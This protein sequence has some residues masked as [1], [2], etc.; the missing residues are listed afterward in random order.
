[1]Y[2]H[3][4]IKSLN[5]S[6]N[7]ATD[8]EDKLTYGQVNKLFYEKGTKK[9]NIPVN[10]EHAGLHNF[11]GSIWFARTFKSNHST[12]KLNILEFKGIDYFA[13]VWL[14]D[15]FLG[16]HEGYF[17]SF[18]FDIS[19]MLRESGK[20]FLIVKVNSPL[21]EPKKV[22]PYRKRLI[23]GIFNHH[24]CRPGAWSYKY[25][26]DQNTGGIWNEVVL[27]SVDEVFIENVRVKPRIYFNQNKAL[28]NLSVSFYKRTKAVIKD[29]M[30]IRVTSPSGKII[31]LKKDIHLR[32]I[33]HDIN[34]M[35]VIKN[36]ELWWSWDLG[37]PNLYE[38]NISGKF[39]IIKNIKFG[40]REVRINEKK[41]FYLNGKRLFLRGTNVIPALF[42]S[43][44]NEKKIEEQLGLIKDANINIIRMHAHVNR[45]E[46][47]EECDKQGILIWQDFAL[48]WTYDESQ[49]FIIN[50]VA[51]IMDMV[52]LLFNHASIA[53]WCCHNEP[54]KQ[55]ESLDPFL[56]DA[57]RS[58]D[59]SRI[60][61]VAS[62]YEE[63][64][65]DG[66]YWGNK[67]HFAARPMGPLVTEFGAQALPE[68]KS[69]KKI[70]PGTDLSDPSKESWAYHDFQYE[71]TFNIAD[72]NRGKN[73]NE[74]IK[75]S[76]DYQS[77]LL[78]TAIDFYRRGKNK[79]ITGIFQFMF[80]D[81]WPSITWSVIDFYGRKK[82]GY[83][84]LQKGFQPL[85]VSVRAGQRKYFSGQTL[86]IDYWV[87]NDFHE[88]FNSCKIVFR[89]GEKTLF[90]L[91]VKNI[92]EDSITYFNWGTNEIKLPHNLSKGK[93]KMDVEIIQNK[94]VLSR[95]DFE[96]EIV[97]W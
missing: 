37:K 91:P 49:E 35:V 73:L 38:L 34:F 39:I 44:L 4:E 67:E 95:N 42:L 53:F 83:F 59:K 60:I 32:G 27:H 87:I 84:T 6:W 88:M 75:N 54:G 31:T 36:P 12:S 16:K 11:S 81:C 13:S 68:Q 1:M 72:I 78:K 28:L 65:Y 23:K 51:Q 10:W 55:I 33:K 50:A 2:S 69:L 25:G 79:D 82:K 22:W 41:E 43:E 93:Y 9:I 40:I 96:I 29:K 20:N 58:I 7:Y 70:I 76:Q 92:P 77:E 64:P 17:Q 97:N 90:K 5:G 3:G 85:Y 46:F 66:W 15:T 86:N 74:F 47:Y 52:A 19:D 21:E 26:Q 71:Q 80:I 89:I 14:N 24:D 63:H 30:E 57:V 48:Q 18:Y 62:N 94:I 61:R 56:F 45:S 8:A